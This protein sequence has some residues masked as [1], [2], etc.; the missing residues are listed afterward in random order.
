MDTELLN[1]VSLLF[2]VMVSL[3]FIGYALFYIFAMTPTELNDYAVSVLRR[4]SSDLFENKPYTELMIEPKNTVWNHVRKEYGKRLREYTLEFIF[5]SSDISFTDA[6]MFSA[7]ASRPYHFEIDRVRGLMRMTFISKVPLNMVVMMVPYMPSLKILS[8]TTSE[9]I[10]TVSS[11]TDFV[12][13]EH[14]YLY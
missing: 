8:L 7:S 10:S 14:A 1:R 4:Q 3:I 6:I 13:E 11:T 5:D 9:K 12:Y 2:I